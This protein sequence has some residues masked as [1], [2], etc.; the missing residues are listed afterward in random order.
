MPRHSENMA[1]LAGKCT[2]R[3]LRKEA[4]K[5][6]AVLLSVARESGLRMCC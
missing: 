2:K 3:D 4:L 1:M 6:T 5:K